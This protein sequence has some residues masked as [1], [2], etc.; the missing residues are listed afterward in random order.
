MS[1]CGLFCSVH[2]L[3]TIL[4]E[5]ST[6]YRVMGNFDLEYFHTAVGGELAHDVC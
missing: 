3:Y 2:L 6:K 1:C 5:S 4:E